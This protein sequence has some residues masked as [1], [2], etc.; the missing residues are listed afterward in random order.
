MSSGSDANG[1]V[2][3]SPV[4]NSAHDLEPPT[5][6]VN[7]PPRARI[8]GSY[9]VLSLDGGGYRG[10]VSLLILKDL[11]EQV[12]GRTTQR[13]YPYQHFDII[14]G[15]STGGLA[16]ILLGVLHLDIDEAIN[17]YKNLGRRIFANNWG[18]LRWFVLDERFS[19]RVLRTNIQEIL[20]KHG[21]EGMLMINSDRGKGCRV[22]FLPLAT[23]ASNVLSSSF[24]SALLLLQPNAG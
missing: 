2:H 12:T 20:K 15:T 21:C 7:L 13:I 24:I 22:R 23:V 16:A 4:A 3:Q 8:P 1:D 9:N 14:C 11:L 6:H 18:W 5:P 19:S 17:I 10:L